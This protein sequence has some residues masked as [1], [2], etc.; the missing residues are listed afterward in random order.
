MLIN[1]LLTLAGCPELKKQLFLR[2]LMN[3][4][5]EKM[6]ASRTDF[7]ETTSNWEK[8]KEEQVA[9][10]HFVMLDDNK[11]KVYEIFYKSFRHLFPPNIVCKKRSIFFRRQMFWRHF[12]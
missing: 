9:T 1:V 6:I 3:L 12:F 10:W 11:N 7:H 4:M 2:D 5:L 8:S